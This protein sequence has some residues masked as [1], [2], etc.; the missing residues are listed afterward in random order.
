MRQ[1]QAFATPV[2]Q[3]RRDANHR[4]SKPEKHGW[5]RVHEILLTSGRPNLADHRQGPVKNRP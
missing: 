1:R 2:A 4:A 3:P 5:Q